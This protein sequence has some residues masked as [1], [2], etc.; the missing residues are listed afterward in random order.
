MLLFGMKLEGISPQNHKARKRQPNKY[1]SFGSFKAFI[2]KHLN[3]WVL[4]IMNKYD[5]EVCTAPKG[6]KKGY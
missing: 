1:V 6:Y 2:G 5:L 3:F 4:Q